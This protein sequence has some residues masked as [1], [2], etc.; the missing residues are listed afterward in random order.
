MCGTFFSLSRCGRPGRCESNHPC[1]R[2]KDRGVSTAWSLCPRRAQAGQ[3]QANL[4]L[5]GSD[6]PFR[7]IQSVPSL[8][9]A[10]ND[11][12]LDRVKN[13]GEVLAHILREEAQNKISVLLEQCILSA[14]PSVSVGICKMLR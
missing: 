13:V 7:L 4:L 3:R 10:M 8:F 12:C 2:T 14:V 6:S 11:C 5:N 9:V 1:C